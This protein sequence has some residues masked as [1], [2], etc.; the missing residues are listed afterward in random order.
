M[1]ENEN[2]RLIKLE[3]KFEMLAETFTKAIERLE[4]KLDHR[5]ENFVTKEILE[6]KLR[7]RDQRID[8]LESGKKEHLNR[9]PV[10][11]S[12]LP[13]LAAVIVAIIAIYK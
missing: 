2:E 13:S 11:I 3:T 10:W 9:L 1:S 4:K 7:Q 6:E 8:Q 5:E 12:I